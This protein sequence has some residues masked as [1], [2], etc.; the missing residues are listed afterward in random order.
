MAAD[1]RVDIE[2]DETVRSAMN[3]EIRFVSVRVVAKL[4]KNTA[5]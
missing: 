4:A 1:V 5:V 2:N 3:D